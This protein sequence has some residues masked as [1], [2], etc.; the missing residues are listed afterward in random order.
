MMHPSIHNDPS[1]IIAS[2]LESCHL[3]PSTAVLSWITEVILVSFI[4]GE[5]RLC[6]H[7]K[8]KH[9]PTPCTTWNI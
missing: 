5:Q 9:G 4:A 2:T 6:A 3:R 8:L 1:G 7:M